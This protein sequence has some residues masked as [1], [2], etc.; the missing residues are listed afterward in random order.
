MSILL[1]R[2]AGGLVATLLVVSLP[3]AALATA[4]WAV[5]PEVNTNESAPYL[6]STD[7]GDDFSPQNLDTVGE[8]VGGITDVDATDGVVH[9]IF[10]TN[11]DPKE[12]FPWK[13]IYRRSTDGGNHFGDPVRV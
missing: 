1:R 5:D 11:T 13:V 8:G 3:A 9:A 10:S 4:A 2:R 7:G 12:D 6:R